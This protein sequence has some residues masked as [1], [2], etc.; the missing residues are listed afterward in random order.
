MEIIDAYK[1]N[2]C[3][4]LSIPYWKNKYIEI[5][6]NMKILH[7][8][9]F[10]HSNHSEY[11]DEPYFRLYH[12]L[13]KIDAIA[14]DGISIVTAKQDDIPL[15]VEVINQSYT[16]LSVT[17]EQLVMYTQTEVYSPELWVMA[18]DQITD[19][20]AGCGIADFDREL[21]EG[22]I[23]W[24]QVIPAYRG[25]KIGQLIVSELLGRM[26]SI[27]KFAT[28]SGKVNNITTPEKLYRKCG[29]VGHDVWHILTKRK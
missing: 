10:R 16:D 5:P 28:V 23:E 6:P 21:S 22:I 18:V 26:K 2:P 1:E 25:N 15:F 12:S 19:T 29:F 7:E 13:E 17:I 11:M 24:V 20:V 14:L 8:N 4:V 27:A 9:D 3:G